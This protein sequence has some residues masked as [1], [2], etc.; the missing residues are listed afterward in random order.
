MK[1]VIITKYSL[2]SDDD[3]F[4]QRNRTVSGTYNVNAE[5][6]E[7]TSEDLAFFIPGTVNLGDAWGYFLPSYNIKGLTITI[8]PEDEITW[9]GKTWRINT[10]EDSYFGETLWYRKALM[11]RQI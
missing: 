11:K 9:N 1:K 8:A 7:L 3:A 2:S 4:G 6:Q 10:I 5:I